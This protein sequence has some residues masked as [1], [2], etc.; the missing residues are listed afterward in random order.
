MSLQL[1]VKAASK[2][3]W[4]THEKNFCKTLAIKPETRYHKEGLPAYQAAMD[5]EE[6]L[7]DKGINGLTVVRHDSLYYLIDKN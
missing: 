5:L 4:D 7:N 2:V 1:L 6:N 3:Y